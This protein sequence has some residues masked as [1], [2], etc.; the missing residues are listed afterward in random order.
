M[1]YKD[2]IY[3]K[4][5]KD[6]KN[7]ESYAEL[8]KLLDRNKEMH[9]YYDAAIAQ[10]LLEIKETSKITKFSKTPLKRLKE[11]YPLHAIFAEASV[12]VAQKK[13]NEALEK[14][15]EIHHKIQEQKSLLRVYNLLRIAL[16]EKI[17]QHE[18]QE[19]T[20]LCELQTI[21]DTA[22]IPEKQDLLKYLSK[23]MELL[24]K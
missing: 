9:R 21:L 13:Y 8:N 23:R 3:A 6:P 15:Y 2:S 20:A 22:V 1:L 14:S 4:W 10:K 11:E 18:N 17:L 24:Q 12:M 19:L 7:K 5:I 16:L